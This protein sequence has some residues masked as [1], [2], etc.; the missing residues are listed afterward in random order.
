LRNYYIFY[1]W[2]QVLL[3]SDVIIVY[4]SERLTREWMR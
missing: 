4:D 3:G 1:E 2:S